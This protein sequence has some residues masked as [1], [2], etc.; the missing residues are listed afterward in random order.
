MTL[1]ECLIRF[2]EIIV[3]ILDYHAETCRNILQAI[4]NKYGTEKFHSNTFD[5]GGEFSLLGQVQ[6]TPGILLILIYYGNVVVAGIRT[7]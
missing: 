4:I 6:V 7:V 5:D 2:E 3:K 1:T